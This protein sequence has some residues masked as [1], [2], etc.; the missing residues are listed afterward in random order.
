MRVVQVLRWIMS[1]IPRS[2]TIVYV[3]KCL[4]VF[5]LNLKGSFKIVQIGQRREAVSY[6]V[7]RRNL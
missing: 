5:G 4:Y 7:G 6:I 1:F 2:K 3:D